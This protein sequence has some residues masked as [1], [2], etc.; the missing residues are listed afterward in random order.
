MFVWRSKSLKYVLFGTCSGNV[1]SMMRPFTWWRHQM[2]TFSALL[3]LCEG[4]PPVTGGLPLRASNVGLWCFLW[5]APEQT[6]RQTKIETLAGDL[7]RHRH[8]YDVTLTIHGHTYHRQVSS[9]VTDH[10]AHG[11]CY[12]HVAMLSRRLPNLKAIEQLLIISPGS[13]YT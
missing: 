6:V 4:N 2:E 11:I 13:F 7:G 1:I 10:L 5:S 12:H 9:V 3:A 8:Y